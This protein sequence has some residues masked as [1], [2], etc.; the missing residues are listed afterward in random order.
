MIKNNYNNQIDIIKITGQDPFR[1]HY[2]NN[3]TNR[4]NLTYAY[5]DDIVEDSNK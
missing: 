3:K 2:L 5:E 4:S 1:Q